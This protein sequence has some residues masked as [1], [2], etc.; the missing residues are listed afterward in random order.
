MA[1][2]SDKLVKLPTRKQK[3]WL[4]KKSQKKNLGSS[5]S[6]TKQRHK[7]QLY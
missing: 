4:K 2:E 7:D 1:I 6:S 5:N 3:I